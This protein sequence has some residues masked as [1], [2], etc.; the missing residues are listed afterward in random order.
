MRYDSCLV[1]LMHKKTSLQFSQCK[2]HASVSTPA[3]NSVKSR[4][5][6]RSVCLHERA[7]S[8]QF[9]CGERTKLRTTSPL[10]DT[11]DGVGANTSSLPVVAK[12]FKTHRDLTSFPFIRRAQPVSK[13]DWPRGTSAS[14]VQEY[15]CRSS[16]C[17]T[18]SFVSGLDCVGGPSIKARS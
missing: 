12:S 1:Q 3:K 16:I 13:M 15:N 6:C 2:T 11:G 17:V 14:L 9:P 4:L 8:L 18:L 10:T 7:H 5:A